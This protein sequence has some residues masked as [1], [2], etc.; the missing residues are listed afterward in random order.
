MLLRITKHLRNEP[1]FKCKH[2]YKISIPII[3][4]GYEL[5]RLEFYTQCTLFIIISL[6]GMKT[7]R[8]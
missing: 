4:N 5:I 1:V 7:K 6:S 3:G 8:N 2:L